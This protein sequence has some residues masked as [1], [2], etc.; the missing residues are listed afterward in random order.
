M[1]DLSAFVL[2]GGRST[3]M[4]TDKAFLELNGRSLLDRAIDLVSVIDPAPSIV[5]RA[6]K[7]PGYRRVVEDEFLDR[8]P[9]GGIHAALRASK[10]NLNLVLAV[11][12]PFVEA[13]FLKFL[14]ELAQ[15]T[16]TVVTVPRAGGHWQPLCAVYG[17]KFGSLAETALRQGQNKIDA[18]FPDIDVRVIEEDEL[19]RQGFSASMFRNLNTPEE[20]EEAGKVSARSRP[21]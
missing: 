21:A 16:R 17:K 8:G 10:A 2:A 13:D 3:R 1:D 6:A 15:S 11:D 9:L 12:M 5:G 20:L 4:G 19:V 18:L 7:F 14:V